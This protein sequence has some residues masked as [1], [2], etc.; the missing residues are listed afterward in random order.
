VRNWRSF[1]KNF[2]AERERILW[3][4]MALTAAIALADAWVKSVS[5]GYLYMVPIILVSGALPVWGVPIFVA[6]CLLLA[7]AFGPH[8]D[9]A[10]LTGRFTIQAATFLVTGLLSARIE[11]NRQKSEHQLVEL[12]RQTLLRQEAEDQLTA[13]IDTSL[14]AILT[15]DQDGVIL[16]TNQSAER[17]F[18]KA[19]GES[20]HGE[21]I[22]KYLPFLADRSTAG[23]GV[24]LRTMMEGRAA[25]ADH[26]AFYAQIWVSTYNTSVGIRR[27]LIVWD[28]S[29]QRREYEELG[30]QQLL[31]SSRILTGAVAHEVRNMAAAISA[32]SYQL[33]LMPELADNPHLRAL[34]TLVASL[35][36]FAS[37]GLRSAAG[38][39]ISEVNLRSLLDEITLI[40]EPAL[41][42]SGARSAWEIQ[43]N[44]PAVRAE[45]AALLQVLLN[46]INNALRA[47][48]EREHSHVT[49][50]SYQLGDRAVIRVS[51]DGQEI[52]SADSLFEPFQPGAAASGLG[53]YVSRA[54]V[55]TFGGNLRFARNNGMNHFLVELLPARVKR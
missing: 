44:L 41:Q 43:E 34:N 55:R 11:H 48:S 15:I 2:A 16:L 24:M 13:F 1:A 32:H 45:R 25:R 28:A 29:E 31:N 39:N 52:Q 10:L 22:V 18:G 46:L 9:S 21:E 4:G 53:L 35:Q 37:A 3:A 49:V 47:V 23:S 5:L 17:M 50:A 8:L 6:C 36:E 12:Q 20:L 30:L 54:I 7:Q 33:S 14:A 38:E 40:V 27:A 19:D 26:S 51:N 42:E